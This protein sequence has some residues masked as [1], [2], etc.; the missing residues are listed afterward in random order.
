VDYLGDTCA[1]TD[2]GT[3]TLTGTINSS[4][5]ATMTINVGDVLTVSINGTLNPSAKPPFSG[6]LTTS[7][8]CG[9]GGE[10]PH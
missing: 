3:R 5:Q 7:G 9:S 10:L 8:P 4:N 6:A 2:S 1:G